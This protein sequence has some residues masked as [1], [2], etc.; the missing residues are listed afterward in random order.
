MTSQ[1]KLQNFKYVVPNIIW[2][3][4]NKICSGKD[5]GFRCEGE[6][7]FKSLLLQFICP[8]IC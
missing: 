7:K 6:F 1:K 2:T 3:S 5:F 4:G 8:G